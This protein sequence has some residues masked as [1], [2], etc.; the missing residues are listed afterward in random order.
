MAEVIDVLLLVFKVVDTI[1]TTAKLVKTNNEEMTALATRCL[2]LKGPLQ[3]AQPRLTAELLMP[4][5]EA[6][7]AAEVL[8][9]KASQH[10]N[11][12]SAGLRASKCAALPWP[13]PH[14]ITNACVGTAS[15][16]RS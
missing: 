14:M 9:L 1:V 5:R 4:L 16:W 11:I 2:G 7:C 10:T 8:V 6:L 12:V 13:P 3:A 15:G